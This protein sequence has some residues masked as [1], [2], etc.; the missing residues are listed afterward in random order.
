MSTKD[1]IDCREH[2]IHYPACLWNG[3]YI[4][5]P[6]RHFKDKADVVAIVRC[7]DCMDALWV[8]NHYICCGLGIRTDADFYCANGERREE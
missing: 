5:T 3:E 2:C 6:C 8:E 1:K 7:R 4:P